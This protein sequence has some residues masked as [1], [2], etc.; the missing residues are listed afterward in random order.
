MPDEFA[1]A[2]RIHEWFKR[3]L[4]KAEP[5]DNRLLKEK[6][7]VASDRLVDIAQQDGTKI[8]GGHRR[9]WVDPDD[10]VDI[11]ETITEAEKEL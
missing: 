10:M 9:V 7:K 4:A 2:E 1:N 5:D 8:M 11:A 3:A 6:L